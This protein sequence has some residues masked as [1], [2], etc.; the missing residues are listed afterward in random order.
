MLKI[1][2]KVNVDTSSIALSWSN[3]DKNSIAREELIM[4]SEELQDIDN[5]NNENAASSK[6][7]VYKDKDKTRIA[8]YACDNGN[9]K[10]VPKFEGDFPK[11]IESTIRPWWK[12]SNWVVKSPKQALW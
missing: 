10:A 9:S 7:L 11:L 1:K 12:S 6:W 5:N 8:R 3:K 4:T 2:Q